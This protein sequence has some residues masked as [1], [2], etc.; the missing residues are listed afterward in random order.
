MYIIIKNNPD[1]AAIEGAEIFK[2]AAVKAFSSRRNFF[3]ALSGGS[4]PRIMNRLLDQP[5]FIKEI[6]WKKTHI[7]WVDDRCVDYSDP[8]SNYGTAKK[9]FIDRAPI[10]EN[11]VHP[12]PFDPPHDKAAKAY[13]N[14]IEKSFNITEGT[15]PVFDLIFLGIGTDGHT[16]SLFPET[17]VLD[18]KEKLI[19]SVKGGNP[20][21]NRLTMTFP[22]INHAKHIVVLANGKKKAEIIKRVIIDKDPLLPAQRINPVNGKLTWILDKEAGALL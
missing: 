3:V 16:A 18:E 8:A 4:T 17:S 10:P 7:F 6:P 2:Y 12:M 13:Q 9:D 19:V 11:H 1:H 15:I 21:V 22:V 5:P 20:Y 14:E